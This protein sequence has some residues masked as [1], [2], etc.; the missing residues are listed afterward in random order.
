[1]QFVDEVRITVQAGHGGNGIVAF[2]REKTNPLGGPSGGDGGDGGD[3]E[4]EATERLSTLLD[5]HYR[6]D[7]K[8]QNGEHGRGKDQYG[9][10]GRGVVVR[11]PVGTQVYDDETDELIAD[12]DRDGMRFIVARGGRGGFGNMHFA[13]PS[14]RI[15]RRAEPGERG[16]SRVLRLELKLLADVGVVGFPNVGKSTFIAAVSAARPKIADYPFTTL[17]PNLGVASLGPDRSFVI[18]DIPGIIEGAAEGA[19]LGLRFLRHV[20]RCRVLLHVVAPDPDPEREVL[21]D[22]DVLENELASFDPELVKRPRVVALGKIDLLSLEEREELIERF[23]ARGV[24]VLPM[25]AA[26]HAGTNDV[27]VAL[28]RY[29]RR[30]VSEDAPWDDDAESSE[31]ESGFDDEE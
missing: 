11:V 14:E 19:G 10:G 4:L 31:D 24:H 12:L 7:I 18:A 6:R 3:I 17:V 25:S 22:F 23:R 26:T 2:R 5:L 30:T 9:K 21:A 15:P 16:E 8:A 13:S 29:V 1:V 27:L 28:E 20:E